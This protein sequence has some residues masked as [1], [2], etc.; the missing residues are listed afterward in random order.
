MEMVN[1]V[2]EED[3]PEPWNKKKTPVPATDRETKNAARANAKN[4]KVQDPKAVDLPAKSGRGRKNSKGKGVETAKGMKKTKPM[5]AVAIDVLLG[6]GKNPVANVEEMKKKIE[7]DARV[8][9]R[10]P[11]SVI[12]P[13]TQKSWPTTGTISEDVEQTGG[14]NPPAA[15]PVPNTSPE[16]LPVEVRSGRNM[17]Q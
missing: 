9:G 7:E 3:R 8:C 6:R 1:T 17:N 4:D 14:I 5:P 13:A 16:I 12:N 15:R 10:I 11:R 2:R